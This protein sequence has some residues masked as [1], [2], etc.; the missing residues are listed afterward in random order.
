M[1]ILPSM[2]VE[3]MEFPMVRIGNVRRTQASSGT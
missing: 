3:L 1:S 2:I